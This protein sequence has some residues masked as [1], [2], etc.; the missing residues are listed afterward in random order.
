MAARKKTSTRARPMKTA[1]AGSRKRRARSAAQP[2][3]VR[4]RMYRQ[5]FGDCLLVELPGDKGEP[6]RLLI[7]CGVLL[8]TSDA[9]GWMRKVVES[10]IADTDGFVDVLVVTHEHW[11]HVSGFAQARDLFSTDG[12]AE[13]KLAVGNVWL[14]WTEDPADRLANLLRAERRQQ[15]QS[16]IGF[17][18]G[19]RAAGPLTALP[20]ASGLA[21]VLGFFA[22]SATTTANALD[23]AKSLA[24]NRYLRPSD[25]PWQ[26]ERAGGVRIYVLGP[27][28]DAAQIRR[29]SAKS[30]LYH[31]LAGTTMA[32][33][34][35]AAAD[36]RFGIAMDAET[37]DK[38]A[39]QRPFDR[40]EWLPIDG[41]GL[42][43]EIEQVHTVEEVAKLRT[44][45]AEHYWGSEDDAP[46]ESWRRIDDDWLG[47]A[48]EL[49]LHLDSATNN[50][51]L[52][53]AIELVESRKVLLFAADAQVGNWLSWHD[54]E[55]KLD[56]DTV[57]KGRDLI[58]RTVFYKVG[59]HGSHNATLKDKG[60][61]LMRSEG[62]VAFVP[63][64]A[65][66]A[67]SRNWHRIPFSPLMEA[68]ASRGEVVRSD[69]GAPDCD[70][71]RQTDMYVE[72]T[73]PL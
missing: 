25:P 28:P 24:P 12:K 57:V 54:L 23:I 34:F 35:F 5:G 39:L 61:E 41:D 69:L 37:A 32:E 3:G 64:D 56:K 21:N 33:A 50:T 29:L 6:F 53:L 2:P 16:L 15:L 62:L 22:L 45:F 31:Q 1:S 26:S 42:T 71:F 73:V 44:F 18:E 30:E 7:D 68:L 72:Y 55:W 58:E 17:V 8:G 27:P 48:S 49:A 70:G 13:G 52:V 20:L 47:A 19:L 46:D 11:D 65:E 9:A 40:T 10:I 51:S 66:T 36:R 60:L 38:L 43:A 59:H 63:V 67:A 4:V 14:A